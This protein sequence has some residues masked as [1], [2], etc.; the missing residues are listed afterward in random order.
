MRRSVYIFAIIAALALVPAAPYAE[1]ENGKDEHHKTHNEKHHKMHH[2]GSHE[3][4]GDANPLI[5]EMVRLDGVF[6][7]VVSG[8]AL[9]DGE[10]VHEALEQMHG[11]MEKTHEGVHSGKVVIRKNADRLD[12]FVRMDK[13]FHESLERLAHVA[14]EGD[15]QGMLDITQSLL[16][17]CVECHKAYR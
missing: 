16:R 2:E 5:E 7:E 1:Q 3:H 4:G 10:K 17:G 12:E 13:E 9:G 6:R 15:Q 11:T 14:H 8:V